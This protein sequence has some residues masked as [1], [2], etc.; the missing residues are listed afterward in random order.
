MG[1]RIARPAT[2]WARIAT[3]RVWRDR[4]NRKRR[5]AANHHV[6]RDRVGRGDLRGFH[7]RRSDLSWPDLFRSPPW[8]TQ[9]RA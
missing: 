2:P 7:D 9:C 3:Q 1:E 4:R 6:D 5:V 8:G